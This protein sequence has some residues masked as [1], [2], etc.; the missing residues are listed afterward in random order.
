MIGIGCPAASNH[1]VRDILAS[2][3]GHPAG[4]QSHDQFVPLARI[5]ATGRG[6]CERFARILQDVSKSEAAH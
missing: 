5:S 4:R 3:V 2:N 6:V 1:G